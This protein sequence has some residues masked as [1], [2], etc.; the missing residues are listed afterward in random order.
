M[1]LTADCVVAFVWAK[2]LSGGFASWN[3]SFQIGETMTFHRMLLAILAAVCFAGVSPAYAVDT[4]PVDSQPIMSGL[5]ARHVD[6]SLP[7]SIF[8]TFGTRQG[9]LVIAPREHRLAAGRLYKL[10]ITNPSYLV[11]FVEVPFVR[12]APHGPDYAVQEIILRP[13]QSTAMVFMTDK[14]GSFA[15]DCALPGHRKAGMTSSVIVG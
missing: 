12:G 15:L 8:A 13:G 9:E 14:K 7:I 5:E 6:T 10:V 2:L 11:H 4:W 3:E 1:S